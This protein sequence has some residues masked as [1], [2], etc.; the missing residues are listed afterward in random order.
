FSVSVDSAP[1]GAGIFKACGV[2]RPM[3]YS[4]HGQRA[5]VSSRAATHRLDEPPQV[6]PQPV[7]SPQSRPPF[8]LAQALYICCGTRKASMVLA[9]DELAAAGELLAICGRG[10]HGSLLVA[11]PTYLAASHSRS[12]CAGAR[13]CSA[14]HNF[15]SDAAHRPESMA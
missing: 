11:Q 4:G 6:I 12:R 7:A 3:T 13:C 9:A 5:R 8:R 2:Y 14:P 15:G 10:Q 1:R